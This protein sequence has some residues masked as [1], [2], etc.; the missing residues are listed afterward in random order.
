M[1]EA[2]AISLQVAADEEKTLSLGVWIF[3][4]SEAM[5]FGGLLSSFITYRYLYATIFIEASRHLK[6]VL[7][8][9]NTAV[10]LTSSA[11]MACAV[12]WSKQRA[13]QS[14]I[15]AALSITFTLGITFLIIKAAE[16]YLEYKDSLVPWLVFEWKGID[17]ARAKLF[18]IFYFFTTGLHALHML[19]G[20]GAIASL[21]VFTK[22]RGVSTEAT[23]AIGLYWHFVDMVWVFLF[24]LLYLKLRT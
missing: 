6:I 7:G 13:N 15:L 19:L 22:V 2:G 11:S 5:L 4:I 9:V 3:L 1:A 17:P 24:P 12:Y 14:R 10:L 20:L 21:A 16:Y 18:F 8:S 23:Q